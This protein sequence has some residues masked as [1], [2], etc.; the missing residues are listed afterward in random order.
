MWSSAFK[1]EA[2][3]APGIS[4]SPGDH[5][6]RFIQGASGRFFLR[7]NSGLKSLDWQ[8]WPP[9]ARMVTMVLPGP[10]SRASRMAP[11]ML[12]ALQPPSTSPSCSLRSNKTGSASSSVICL[13][14]SIDA[15]NYLLPLWPW[16][17]G[18]G[19][20]LIERIIEL[21]ADGN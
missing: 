14:D 5:L 16:S 12:I 17:I 4:G 15:K 20:F 6:A 11:T 19:C 18:G 10:R 13:V 1:E 7:K 3:E 8:R 9:S 21:D 2:H